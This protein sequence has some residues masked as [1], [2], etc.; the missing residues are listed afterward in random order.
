MVKRT[1]FHRASAPAKKKC[2][3]AEVGDLAG[4]AHGRQG[5]ADVAHRGGGCGEIQRRKCSTRI[6]K[7]R[8]R[9]DR[10]YAGVRVQGFTSLT[11]SPLPPLVRFPTPDPGR[12]PRRP[13][14]AALLR[15]RCCVAKNR[16]KLPSSLH[17][18]HCRVRCCARCPRCRTCRRARQLASRWLSSGSHTDRQAAKPAAVKHAN[19]DFRSHATRI[20]V[21]DANYHPRRRPAARSP[22]WSYGQV[23]IGCSCRQHPVDL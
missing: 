2:G 13:A 17:R 20:E 21:I 14:A 9:V 11:L 10:I 12:H 19:T 4:Q 5:V 8:R 3:F 7:V 18:A 16:L 22:R 1:Q 23:C 15:P 6:D